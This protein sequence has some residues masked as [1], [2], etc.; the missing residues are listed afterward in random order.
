MLSIVCS[1]NSD[2][3]RLLDAV[4]RNPNLVR[5]NVGSSASELKTLLHQETPDIA[6]IDVDLPG[7]S[8]Y[9][10]SRFI[11]G[12]PALAKTHVILVRRSP[13]DEDSAAET[14]SSGANDT[15]LLPIHSDDFDCHISQCTSLHARTTQRVAA[16]MQVLLERD[17]TTVSGSVLN[18][19]SNGLGLEV[20]KAIK[21]GPIG[22]T[23]VYDSQTYAGI[24]GKVIWSRENAEGTGQT[25]GLS[26]GQISPAAKALLVKLS[27]FQITE[28]PAG[29]GVT[30]ALQGGFDE[31]TDFELLLQKLRGIPHIDFMMQGLSYLSSCGVRSWCLF[32]EALGSDVTYSFRNCSLAFSSQAA[33]V[34]MAIGSGEVISMQAPYFCDTC[35]REESRLIESKLVRR[36]SGD[37]KPP[38][39]HCQICKKALV[40]D[41][42]PGRY[43][44]FLGQ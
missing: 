4:A 13:L 28:N 6:I 33:M 38:P 29:G 17:G 23:L 8:G 22:I 30:V 9:E 40:F 14:S 3:L 41:D 1:N 36:A 25:V 43:F 27:L 7:G 24:E 10:V 16:D 34:P 44:A 18:L 39:M 5:R 12:D 31:R 42:I 15:I 35:D 32:I 2:I 11:K 21:L 37:L 19:T 26:F 20:E